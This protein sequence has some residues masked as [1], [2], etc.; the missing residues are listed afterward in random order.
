MKRYIGIIALILTSHFAQS[1]T[2]T[3]DRIILWENKEPVDDQ[4][5]K[6]ELD[7]MEEDGWIYFNVPKM[8]IQWKFKIESI[9]REDGNI[10][11]PCLSAQQTK[12][13]IAYYKP[14]NEF[15]LKLDEKTSFVLQHIK[16]K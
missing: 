6:G 4:F 3:F 15:V 10:F 5:M 14:D 8:D 1:Q 2:Y 16:K 13:F 11:Y 9:D 12:V 7:I